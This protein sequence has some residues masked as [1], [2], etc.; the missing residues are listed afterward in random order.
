MTD[1][2]TNID[3]SRIGISDNL[4]ILAIGK[5]YEKHS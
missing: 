1:S 2:Y 4:P 5:I 3:I